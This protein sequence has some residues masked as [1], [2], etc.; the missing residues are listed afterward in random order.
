MKSDVA[1]SVNL[2]CRMNDTYTHDCSGKHS[3]K[4][5]PIGRFKVFLLVLAVGLLVCIID[6]IF[7]TV[8]PDLMGVLNYILGQGHAPPFAAE[9]LL[10]ASVVI[11]ILSK[12]FLFP[13]IR[14]LMYAI[15]KLVRKD[16]SLAFETRYRAK[17]RYDVDADTIQST[18]DILNPGINPCIMIGS[19][20]NARSKEIK[21][22]GKV[23][24]VDGL[25]PSGVKS[26]FGI[27]EGILKENKMG[28]LLRDA[29]IKGW[30]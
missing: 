21:P 1:E 22:W 5:E 2:K 26:S 27:P 23:F 8:L 3:F 25:S 28:P 10:V 7:K 30:L 18:E 11:F 16:G 20:Q 29:P 15:P 14:T 12:Y 13:V 17:F 19:I 9:S 4:E 6:A 24:I